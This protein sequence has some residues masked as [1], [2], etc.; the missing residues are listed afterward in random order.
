M[1]AVLT[2]KPQ[3]VDSPQKRAQFTVCILGCGLKGIFFA[4]AFAEAGFSVVCTDADQSMV[5]RLSKASVS[6]RDRQRE[7][8]L[9]TNLRKE[10]ITVTSDVSAAISASDIIVIT[11]SPKVEDKKTAQTSDVLAACK[12]VGTVLKR[13]SLIIYSGVAGIGF[14]ESFVKETVENT[15][16]LKAGNDFGLA[17]HPNLAEK[18]ENSNEREVVAA[19]DKFSLNSAAAIFECISKMGVTKV[20]NTK[21]A[22]ATALFAA[23]KRDATMALGNELA[24][25]CENMNID[26][27][28]ALHLLKDSE[29][30]EPS[31][32]E[33]ANRNETYL[34][35]EN[36]ESL[37]VKLR[38]P[39]LARQI[40]EEMIKH[41]AN[42]TQEALRAG[43]GTIRR[44]KLALLGAESQSAATFAQLL[45][46]KGAKITRFSPYF[47]CEANSNQTSPKKT[48][49][50]AV[51]GTNVIAIF[52][53]QD[54]LGRLN[55]KKL[56]ALMKPPAIIV[57]L[58][59][60]MEPQKVEAAGFIYRGLGRGGNKK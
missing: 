24:I 13:G 42:V 55:L 35:L 44:T 6:L 56:R 53:A 5:K 52:S 14:T 37:N 47:D 12:Q 51:E 58:V 15:S 1:P 43:G 38:L 28:E 33:E 59:G 11:L 21:L 46:A 19:N 23:V 31:L 50:E 49:N 60:A 7:A 48:L 2:L 25:L 10:Q 41:A 34:L 36:A 18:K 20:S 54:Q 4:L 57:D 26:Y 29:K 8:K 39:V 32:I 9:K 3:D 30:A 22:E 27:T 45:E 17:Y 16:G 40:N